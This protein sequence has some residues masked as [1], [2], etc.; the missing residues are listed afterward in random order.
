MCFLSNLKAVWSILRNCQQIYD[1]SLR[2]R[3]S[4]LPRLYH[5]ALD[6]FSL[7]KSFC[8]LVSS[9]DPCKFGPK[10][11]VLHLAEQLFYV[12]AVSKWASSL[13]NIFSW[14]ENLLEK[15]LK[16]NTIKQKK[17]HLTIQFANIYLCPC[18]VQNGNT[19][20]T[21]DEVLQQDVHVHFSKPHTRSHK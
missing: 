1:S 4:V 2:K 16:K 17:S 12:P 6:I 21:I 14:K 3:Q 8:G 5:V 7:P 10:M 15:S 9:P 18:H 20:Q 19:Q 13:I 11:H